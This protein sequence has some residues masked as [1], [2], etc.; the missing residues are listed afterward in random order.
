MSGKITIIIAFIITAVLACN[1]VYAINASGIPKEKQSKLAM[2]F[3]SMEANAYIH[4]HDSS[5]LFV[6]VRDPGE[7][8]TLGMP[9]VAD[10][11]IPFRYINLHKWNEV[12]KTFAMDQNP[13]FVNGIEHFLAKKRLSKDDTIIIICSS[14]KRAPKAVNLLASAGYKNVYAVVDGYEGWLHNNLPWSR[15]LDRNKMYVMISGKTEQ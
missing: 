14:G 15:K 5:T 13:D 9:T 12:K 3:T 6:D 2:Y 4:E 8:F 10:A 1:P 11:A 7:I